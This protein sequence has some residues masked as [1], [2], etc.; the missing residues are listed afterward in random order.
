M[1]VFDGDVYVTPH[2]I[3]TQYKTYDFNSKDTLSSI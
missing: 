1:Y 3:T 2:E